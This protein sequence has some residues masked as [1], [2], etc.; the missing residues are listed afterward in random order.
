VTDGNLTWVKSSYSGSQGGNCL[1]AA[2]DGAGRVL[3][4]DTKDRGGAMLE[5]QASRWRELSAS[6]KA[7]SGRKLSNCR[8]SR[9]ATITTTIRQKSPQASSWDLRR[10]LFLLLVVHRRGRE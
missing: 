10:F 9:H 2:A 4:R 1:E 3:V 6:L 8:K 7:E 5:F